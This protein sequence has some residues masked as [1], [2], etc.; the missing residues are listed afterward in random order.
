[1][2][3]FYFHVRS[4]SDYDFYE[5]CEGT[6]EEMNEVFKKLRD[7]YCMLSPILKSS[8]VYPNFS[9]SGLSINM[10]NEIV[11]SPHPIV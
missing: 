8:S 4:W 3:T 7:V 11:S 2:T 10:F 1:M 5:L 9:H 6:T